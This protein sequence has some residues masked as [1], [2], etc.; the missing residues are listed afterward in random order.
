MLKKSTKMSKGAALKRLAAYM[1]KMVPKGSKKYASNMV[2]IF[3]KLTKNRNFKF[4]LKKANKSW[5]K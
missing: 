4:L 1:K 2:A 5:K 3:S